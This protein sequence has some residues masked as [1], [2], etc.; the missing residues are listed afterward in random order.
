[1]PVTRRF[2]AGG[3]LRIN[4][5]ISHLETYKTVWLRFSAKRKGQA[6]VLVY[7]GTRT[8]YITLSYRLSS[9]PPADVRSGSVGA[10]CTE[11]FLAGSCVFLHG[12][13]RDPCGI[14]IF[15]HG[16]NNER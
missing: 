10:S 13:S 6:E 16:H 7:R 3:R 4:E 11:I 14:G 1:M 9:T 5:S 15:V 12:G 2:D 8:F